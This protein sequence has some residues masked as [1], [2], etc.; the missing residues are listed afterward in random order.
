M[1]P[2]QIAAL[3]AAGESETLEFKTS[4][5]RRRAAAQTMCAMLNARGGYVLFGVTPEGEATGQQV[6]ERTVEEVTAEIQMIE[7]P[8]FPE[9]ERIRIA[10]NRE[11]IAVRMGRGRARPYVYRGAAYRRVGASTLTL[12][13][14]EYN[15][16]LF[17][18]MHSEQRW[19]NQPAAGWGVED[20]DADEI[21]ATAA[22]AVRRSRLTEIT[23]WEPAELLRGM[24]LYR[25]GI[26]R[27]AAAVLFGGRSRLEFEMP[28]CFV[29]A[30]RFR[31]PTAWSSPT[32]GS[33]T[34]TPSPFS[35]RRRPF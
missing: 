20:L 3:A 4:T 35:P 11:V 32:I 22:E 14:D 33:S 24:G 26:L 12:S 10:D 7:P 17:E 5:G 31:G 8:A 34:A 25:D 9:I 27:R 30:A 18:R 29:R 23:N 1:T 16:M 21:R 13:P 6:G 15:R 28:Q 19:E 2:E